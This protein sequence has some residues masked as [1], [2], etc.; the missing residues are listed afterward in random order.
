MSTHVPGFQSF[1]RFLH[2][3]VLAELATSSITAKLVRAVLRA[4]GMNGFFTYVK[5]YSSVEADARR[6]PSARKTKLWD[7]NIKDRENRSPL[8]ICK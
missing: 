4:T 2:H 5:M 7:D 6:L 1:Y 8:Y 3:F